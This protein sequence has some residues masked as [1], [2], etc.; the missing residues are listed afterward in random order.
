V[1]LTKAREIADDLKRR[2]EPVCER[3][4]VAGSIRRQKPNPKD[5]ELLVI[6]KY[7]GLADMLDR[8]IQTLMLKGILDC[9]LNKRG[10]RV[11]GP[12]NKLMLHIPSGMA[13]DLFSSTESN[14]GMAL[15]VRTGPKEWNIRAM[16]RLH[17]L[18]MSGHAY[19]G[20]SN[21][22]GSEFNCPDEETIF[23][24]LQWAYVPPERRV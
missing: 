9:R 4:E 19:G 21:S 3:V 18:R 1:E 15:F 12:K 24:Y 22:A 13:V 17:E 14:W 7:N 10:H 2:L 16:S 11:Y 8:E 5:I 23:R 6:P 20:I